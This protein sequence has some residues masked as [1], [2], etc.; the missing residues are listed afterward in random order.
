[1]L[2]LMRS[3]GGGEEMVVKGHIRTSSHLN[4]RS[5]AM[6]H[7]SGHLQTTRIYLALTWV[8]GFHCLYHSQQ[9]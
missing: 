9:E 4:R 2:I 3:V 6:L 1:M 8:L 7:L 5:W